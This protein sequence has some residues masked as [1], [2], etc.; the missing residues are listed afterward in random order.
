MKTGAV[1]WKMAWSMFMLSAAIAAKANTYNV[2]SANGSNS[3]SGL[4]PGQAFLSL[5]KAAIKTVAGDTVF[6]MN[7]TYTSPSGSPLITETDSGTSRSALSIPID[8]PEG[9]YLPRYC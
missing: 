2:D 9:I 7:G 3:N 8:F 5:D 1:K 6:G 4:Q